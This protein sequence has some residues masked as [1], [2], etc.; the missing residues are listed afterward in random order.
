[1]GNYSLGL[2]DDEH[3]DLPD[4]VR[5]AMVRD[6]EEAR[7][8]AELGA[9]LIRYFAESISSDVEDAVIRRAIREMRKRPAL[10]DGQGP[11]NF[12]EEYCVSRQ[13]DYEFGFEEFRLEVLRVLE[14]VI[15]GLPKREQLALWLTTPRGELFLNYPDGPVR[16]VGEV[17][18]SVAHTAEHLAGALDS[19]ALDYENA[20]IRSMT[21]R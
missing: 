11:K 4:E 5:Q 8:G 13:C 1:M 15:E 12:W 21:G 17:P 7:W 9:V 10:M 20:N 18:V 16:A 19:E 3:D 6:L 2:F 14:R